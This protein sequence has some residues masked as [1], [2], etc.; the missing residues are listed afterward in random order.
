MGRS[1]QHFGIVRK[2][3]AEHDQKLERIVGSA[4]GHGAVKSIQADP[5]LKVAIRGLMNGFAQQRQRLRAMAALCKIHGTLP[6][7]SGGGR[8]LARRLGSGDRSER[9]REGHGK[10]GEKRFMDHNSHVPHCNAKP[11]RSNRG[12]SAIETPQES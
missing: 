8:S 12:G 7:A 11:Y 5:L 2:V 3:A 10:S 4:V 6:I 1:V 9:D